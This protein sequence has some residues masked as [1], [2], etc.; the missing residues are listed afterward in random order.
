L[1]VLKL[2]WAN[3]SVV[4]AKG[5]ANTNILIIIRPIYG[6]NGQIDTSGSSIDDARIET[7]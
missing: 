6:G 7:V 2:G 5:I 3:A 1:A 4:T